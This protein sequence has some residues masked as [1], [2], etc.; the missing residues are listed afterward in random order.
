MNEAIQKQLEA[1]LQWLEAAT[2]TQQTW[3]T[4]YLAVIRE[5]AA[6]RSL[7]AEVVA[8]REEDPDGIMVT[9]LEDK[10]PTRGSGLGAT[11]LAR[12]QAAAAGKDVAT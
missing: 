2:M 4:A 1:R 11:L 12:L 10:C 3:P 9:Y 8:A 6:L 5:N 7:C